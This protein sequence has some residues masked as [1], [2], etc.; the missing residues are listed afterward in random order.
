M[1]FY[2]LSSNGRESLGAELLRPT[3]GEERMLLNFDPTEPSAIEQ[4]PAVK[5][6][7]R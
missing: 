5:P 3:L 2:A 1:P 4:D 7:P 6:K